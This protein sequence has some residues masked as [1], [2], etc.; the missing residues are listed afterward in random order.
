[1]KRAKIEW[2][3]KAMYEADCCVSSAAESVGMNRTQFYA[4]V[5]RY[6]PDAKDHGYRKKPQ[7]E[8]KERRYKVSGGNAAWR[9]LG[10]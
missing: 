5:K 7:S 8:R 1:M 9:A 2:L 4:M 3:E 6:L 10:E